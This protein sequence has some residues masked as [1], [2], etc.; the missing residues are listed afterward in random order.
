[1]TNAEVK[2]EERKCPVCENRCYWWEYTC[3]QC[4]W[5]QAYGDGW[6]RYNNVATLRT[7]EACYDHFKHA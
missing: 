1:M 6:C 7:A 3:G 2:T 5:F 4:K